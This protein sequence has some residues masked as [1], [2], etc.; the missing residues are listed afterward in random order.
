MKKYSQCRS[1]IVSFISPNLLPAKKNSFIVQR[2]TWDGQVATIRYAKDNINICLVLF[3]KEVFYQALSFE[4]A[5]LIAIT[6]LML[7]LT[8]SLGTRSCTEL[9][10]RDIYYSVQIPA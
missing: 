1:L 9:M 5:E 4:D 3:W 2:A 7:D 10:G 8:C 6:I